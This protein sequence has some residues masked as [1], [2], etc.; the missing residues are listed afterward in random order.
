MDVNIVDPTSGPLETGQVVE[1]VI[2]FSCASVIGPCG[3]LDID[4]PLD[5]ELEFIEVVAPPGYIGSFSGTPPNIIVNIINNPVTNPT[6]D[7][8]EA[9]QVTVRARVGQDIVDSVIDTTVTGEIDNGGGPIT[10]V[11]NTPSLAISTPSGGW[12]VSKTSVSPSGGLGPAVNGEATYNIAVCPT[13]TE[14]VAQLTELVFSDRFPIGA[15]VQSSNPGT[16]VLEDQ[17]PL[18]APDG[19]DDTIVWTIDLSPV[20]T[21]ED[22]CVDVTYT[23]AYPN[24]PF[25]VGSDITNA[26]FV[27]ATTANNSDPFPDDG[28]CPT[29]VGRS[30]N[31]GTIDNPSATANA[32]KGGPGTA[33]VSPGI[34]IWNKYLQYFVESRTSECFGYR[35]NNHRYLPRCHQRW[36]THYRNITNNNSKLGRWIPS[37]VTNCHSRDARIYNH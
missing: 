33:I 29:C 3:D 24:P 6:F 30:T 19:T 37:T 25:T 28:D 12:D 8:G 7:D 21:V 9:A 10:V 2:D 36:I 17:L 26:S 16:F 35:F 18:G 34:F 15:T 14:G 27:S 4:F 23:L 20:H 31:P 22:G 32:S 1:Y 5:T 11:T 13:T